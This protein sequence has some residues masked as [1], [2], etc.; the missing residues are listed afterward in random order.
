MRHVSGDIARR[1]GAGGGRSRSSV[2]L[3]G[4][5]ARQL[6]CFISSRMVILQLQLK[7]SHSLFG[8]GMLWYHRPQDRMALSV[9]VRG[10]EIDD[11]EIMQVSIL[12]QIHRF[13]V[14][15]SLKFTSERMRTSVVIRDLRDGKIKVIIFA[16]D[17]F[18]P[19]F[20]LGNLESSQKIHGLDIL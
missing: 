6:A 8:C 7:V 13:D 2:L 5:S 18:S 11:S 15:A 1:E 3:P 9:K 10:V 16:C 20:F 17:C 4:Q 19:L 14:L 12:D